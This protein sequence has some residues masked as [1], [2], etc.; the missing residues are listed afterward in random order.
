[1]FKLVEQA[2][3]F[4]RIETR[5]SGNDC[6][7]GLGVPRKERGTTITDGLLAAVH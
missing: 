5:F 1:M 6:E 4:R 7:C 3:L 2:V